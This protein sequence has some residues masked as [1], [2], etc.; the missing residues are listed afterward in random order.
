LEANLALVDAVEG[1]AKKKGCSVGQL[2]LAWLHAQGPDVIPIPGTSSS[3]HLDQNLAALNITLTPE[4]MA[5][6]N[7]ACDPAK[8][9]GDRYPH[10]NM[11][12][13]GNKA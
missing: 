10:M 2:A 4:E 12:F 11:T 8:V 1:I 3:S 13:H 5:E 7:A 6:I 9:A